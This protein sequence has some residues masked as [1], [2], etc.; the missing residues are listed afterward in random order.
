MKKCIVIPDSFKGT[1]SAFE[2]CEIEKQAIQTLDPGCEVAAVPVADGGDGTVDCFLYALK[3]CRKVEVDTTGP[4]GKAQKAYY[5]QLGD[6]AIIEM[7]MCAGLPQVEGRQNPEKTTTYG[8]G[9]VMKKAVEAGCKKLVVGLGG[10]CT[11]DCG[12]GM[13]AALGVVFRDKE[14]KEFVPTGETLGQVAAI[15]L[16]GAKALLEGVEVTAMCDVEN[17]M[18]GPKGAAHVF[19]PQ[20]GADKAMVRRLD[21]GVKQ[22]AE[23]IRSQLGLDLD[24]VPG[25]GAAGA[26]GAGIIAFAGGR[27]QSGI[28]TV[29][30][31]IG[32]EKMLEGTDLVF[33]GEGRIDSQSLDGK[34]ISGIA[35]RAKKQNVPVVCVVGSVGDGIEGAYDMGVS[36]I[37]SINQ[38]AEAFETAR[39]KSA[40]NLKATME[41]ILRLIKASR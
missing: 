22:M 2:I 32:F 5:A 3:D 27:L 1:L 30:D 37:F 28:S 20:K 7:A 10:S 16:S 29:L 11:T 18:Y 4:Y 40:Q 9:T 35:Q 21:E 23:T 39:Y 36:A 24:Q 12:A 33:T 38:K 13:G 25:T 8:V 6:T 17:P 41:N 15:D 19:G 26:M 31:L 14:G 34:V